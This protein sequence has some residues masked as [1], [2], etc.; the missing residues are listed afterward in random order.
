M[1]FSVRKLVYIFF[2]LNLLFVTKFSLADSLKSEAVVFVTSAQNQTF[3]RNIEIVNPIG[4]D[5]V[6]SEEPEPGITK[7]NHFYVAALSIR[8][9]KNYGHYNWRQPFYL[10]LIFDLPPP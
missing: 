5:E 3:L 1:G 7:S 4:L 6:N 8:N 10:P 2:I 9:I